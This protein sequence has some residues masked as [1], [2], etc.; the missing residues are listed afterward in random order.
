M[1]Q[2]FHV[3]EIFSGKAGK[4]VPLEETIDGFSAL[5]NGEGDEIPEAAFYMVGNIDEAYNMAKKLA[6]ELAKD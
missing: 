1:S 2:P 4:F 6:A 5:L 3:A